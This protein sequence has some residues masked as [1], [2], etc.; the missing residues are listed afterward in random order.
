MSREDQ[1]IKAAMQV[2]KQI[3]VL[4]VR[5]VPENEFDNIVKSACEA[6]D[7]DSEEYAQDVK[8]IAMGMLEFSTH[9]EKIS[10]MDVINKLLAA[11]TKD[12]QIYEIL[13]TGTTA[14]LVAIANKLKTESN[15]N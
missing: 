11:S 15:G 3:Y 6:F 5:E 4:S 13:N 10:G 2:S 8:I 14:A 7:L 1:R 12:P 9:V